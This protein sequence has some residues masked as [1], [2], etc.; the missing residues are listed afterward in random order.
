MTAFVWNRTGKISRAGVA[1]ELD[2]GAYLRAGLTEW[3]KGQGNSGAGPV[4]LE[5]IDG[6]VYDTSPPPFGIHQSH[7]GESASGIQVMTRL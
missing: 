1:D 2:T 6:R 3:L 5:V 4:V 7:R